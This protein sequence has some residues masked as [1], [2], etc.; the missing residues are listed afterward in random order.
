M[1]CRYGHELLKELPGG[2]FLDASDG[3]DD[4]DEADQI[5]DVAPLSGTAE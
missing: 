2:A 1:C 4:R 5:A 3:T